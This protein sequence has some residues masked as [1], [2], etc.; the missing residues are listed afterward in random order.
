MKELSDGY[1]V[2]DDNNDVHDEG[3]RGEGGED[4]V[5][6]PA[7]VTLAPRPAGILATLGHVHGVGDVPVV[8]VIVLDMLK[9]F[10]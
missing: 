2:N 6:S 10:H 3:E 1:L 7:F 4:P 5:E 8:G 9:Y